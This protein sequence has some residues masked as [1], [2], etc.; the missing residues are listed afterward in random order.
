MSALGVLAGAALLA[1]K[2]ALGP[3]ATLAVGLALLAAAILAGLLVT[4]LDLLQR[5]AL[6][7]MGLNA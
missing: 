6:R 3:V 1:I 5:L 2:F 4:L 7:R